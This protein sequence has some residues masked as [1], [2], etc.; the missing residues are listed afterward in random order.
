MNRKEAIQLRK[1][2]ENNLKDID[3]DIPYYKHTVICGVSGSGKSTLA[4][5]VIY[6]TA[7]RKLLECL[8]DQDKRFSMKMKK[9]NVGSIEGLSTVISLKQVK[10]NHNPRSTIGTYT[11][12]G[13]C[14]RALIAAYGTCKCMV[15]NQKY[16]QS[17]IFSIGRDL[18]RLPSD[19]VVEVCFPYF[20]HHN[21]DARLQIEELRRQ[22][23][24]LIY[25]EG[26]RKNLRDFIEIGDDVDLI[27]VV[28]SRFQ[29]S[30]PMKK[31]NLNYLKSA[32]EH[33]N[34][35][36]R[37]NLTGSDTQRIE[38]FY[39][40][41]GCPKHHI[42]T[43]TLDSSYF[44]YNEFSC[45]CPECKGSGVKKIV[46][47][48][49]VIRNPKKS[50]KEGPFFPEVYRS[51]YPYWYMLL[52]SLCCHYEIPFEVPYEQLSNEAKE[53]ILYGSKGEKFEL[54]RPRGY[55]KELPHYVGQVGDLV[56]FPGILTNIERMYENSLK[57]PMS[58]EMER[59]YNTYMHEVVC[60]YCKGTRLNKMQSYIELKSKTYPELSELEL[61]ELLS[62]CEDIKVTE[63]LAP[64]RDELKERLRLM[65][66]IGLDY[67]SFHRRIDSL[68][69]GEYQR[70]RIANQVGSGLVGLTYII[71]EPTD[72][73]H[74]SDNQ[75]V[76]QVIQRL[77]EKGN[78][79]ITIEHDLDVIL[80]ADYII[81]MGPGAGSQGG[82]VIACGTIEEIKKNPDSV[83]AQYL[84]KAVNM[85]WRQSNY[86]PQRY[87][88][89]LGAKVHNL[90]QIDVS[91]PLDGI[92]C[93]TGV[94]GSGKSSL[95]FEILY[96]AI[97]SKLHDTRVVPGEY[98]EL[99][100]QE[101]MKDIICIDQGLVNGKNSSIPAS[102]I[103]IF[104]AIRLLFA[105]STMEEQEMKL[106]KSYFSFNSK[107]ACPAC[108]GKGY[109][110]NYIQYFGITKTICK[111]CDGNQ[112]IDEVLQVT[113]HGKNIKQ[114]LEMTFED[115]ESFFFEEKKIHEK[116][117]LACELGLGYLKLG[118]PLNTVSGGEAQRL[119]LIKEMGKN[120]GRK[121][122]IYL[123]DEP[124]IGLHSKDIEYIL[125][126]L[127]R[128]VAVGNSVLVVEHNPDLILNSDYIIDLGP[129]SGKRGGEVMFCGTPEE[130]LKNGVSETAIY[131]RKY[132][133]GIVDGGPSIKE[134]L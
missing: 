45:A 81:E 98:C 109:I 29:V 83:V 61:T 92:T 56:S 118:Q 93:F 32:S 101:Q 100:G 15:C 110:E 38:E 48:S 134:N 111:E 64:I 126:V 112:Y 133:G 105:E 106:T 28:E 30:S 113:Y 73:L 84:T 46:H 71:D 52:Y 79:V 43:T 70:L 77:I 90:K 129:G 104:D 24:R 39:T 97:Y 2:R 53:R 69:G 5:D 87:L 42:M 34:H 35:L 68:S 63:G 119:K 25:I 9:P 54:L 99:I 8:S 37:L 13:S 108:K 41:H 78:T 62:F 88:T 44:S 103:D 55:E 86:E 59:F 51:T 102:Y 12:I 67:L 7:Q 107:G 80:A 3:V 130:L 82:K 122:L 31:S 58:P 4:Y 11:S 114:V 91:I 131:L 96:K 117:R 16:E 94:S 10:P 127:R 66:E 124:T 19:T 1:V 76:I 47:A 57:A 60:P 50:L 33:G 21:S 49:K 115:A 17:S 18:E 23:F 14:V 116:V 125:T 120:R 36:I 6:A 132:V 128:I 85:Q 22:G 123:F 89:V 72:G 26:E 27:E 40:K 65:K 121:N 75:K 20:F 95:L 74:G